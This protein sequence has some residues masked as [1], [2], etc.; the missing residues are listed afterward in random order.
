MFSGVGPFA[1]HIAKRSSANITAVD[2][3]PHA[4]KLLEKSMTLNRLQGI[5][6]PI[7]SDI[8]EYVKSVPTRIADRVIMNHPSGAFNYIQEACYLLKSGGMMHYYDFGG[9]EDPEGTLQNKVEALVKESNRSIRE[10]PLIRRVRD[11]APY[12]YHIVLDAIID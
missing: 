8:R 4:T 2:I 10:A 1:L 3:N 9:G 11:S 7:T 12:E 5:I 6:H